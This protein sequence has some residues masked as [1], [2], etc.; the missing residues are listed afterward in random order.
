[1]PQPTTVTIA[2]T[3]SVSSVNCERD[4]STI[5]SAS[6]IKCVICNTLCLQV[7]RDLRSRLQGEHL[8]AYMQLSI[9]GPPLKGVP[10]QWA[11]EILYKRL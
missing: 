5:N 6:V 1:M 3:I 11:L 10:Y 8:A 7:K 2:L 4:F 9:N